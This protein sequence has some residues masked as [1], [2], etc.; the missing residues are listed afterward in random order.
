MIR[1]RPPPRVV[2]GK[3]VWDYHLYYG[4]VETKGWSVDPKP[5]G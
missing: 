4:L 3:V 5:K 1:A 2:G